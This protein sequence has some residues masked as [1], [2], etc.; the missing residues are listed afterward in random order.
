MSHSPLKAGAS[1]DPKAY[2]GAFDALAEKIREGQSFSGRERN[3]FFLNTRDGKFADASAASGLDLPDDARGSAAVDWDGD[4]DLDLWVANRTAPRLRLMRNDTPAGAAW[5][6]VRL[7]GDPALNCPRDA[8]GARVEVF[9]K[10]DA[11]PR[12]TQTLH[13]GD[14]FLSQGSKVLHFGLGRATG[15]EK[16]V[17]HWP[18]G[19]PET[20]S[21]FQ[22]GGVYRLSQGEDDVVR[23]PARSQPVLKSSKPALPAE[24]EQAR[25]VLAQPLPLPVLSW[26]DFQGRRHPLEQT[27]PGKPLLVNFWSTTCAPCL[28]ELKDFARLGEKVAVLALS[29]ENIDAATPVTAAAAAAVLKKAGF[30]GSSGFAAPEFVRAMDD[31]VQRTIYRHRQLPVPASF[32]ISPDGSLLAIYKGPVTPDQVIADTGAIGKDEETRLN[33]ACP[34]PGHWA[35]YQF[36]SHPLAVAHSLIEAGDPDSARV[37]LEKFIAEHPA[38]P[39]SAQRQGQLG[40]VH[41][42][43]ADLARDRGDLAGAGALYQKAQFFNPAL[44]AARLGLAAALIAEKKDA[45]ALAVLD[46]LKSTPA[47]LDALLAT[48][49]LKKAR[50]DA[51]AALPLYREALRQ[52]PRFVPALISLTSLLASSSVDAVRD[53]PAALQMA[54]FLMSAPGAKQSPRHLSAL[55]AAQAASGQFPEAAKTTRQALRLARLAL[56]ADLAR[57]QMKRLA[58][59]EAGKPWRE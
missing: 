24:S 58:A 49:D 33:L 34:L 54:T 53:A 2:L 45:E 57:D 59:Y 16:V 55:A 9:T 12:L 56:D 13:A 21:G 17:V 35:H 31:L 32:L 50:G 10:G 5:L 47:S 44:H 52:N 4:G 42:M 15:V 43:L 20:Y 25:I 30:T 22:P 40:D 7:I 36:V 38:D 46:A 3:C 27:A 28:A 19:K 18:A 29:V 6:E 51:A 41:L 11:P 1:A 23:E 8:I 14:G 48:A 26:T 37:Q 39:A